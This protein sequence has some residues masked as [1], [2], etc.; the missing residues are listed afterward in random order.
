MPNWAKYIG[1]VVIASL[2]EGT[3]VK[4]IL[5]FADEQFLE[6]LTLDN[7]KLVAIQDIVQFR[8]WIDK[9]KPAIEEK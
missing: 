9:V 5:Q 4:G 6:I 7:I 8:L 1:K 3:Y 2:R